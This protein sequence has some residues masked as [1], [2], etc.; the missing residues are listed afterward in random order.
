LFF[1]ATLQVLADAE[2]KRMILSRGKDCFGATRLAMT[3]FL[4][5]VYEY[6]CCGFGDSGGGVFVCH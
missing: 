4:R 3:L 5:F 1:L 6:S 2:L